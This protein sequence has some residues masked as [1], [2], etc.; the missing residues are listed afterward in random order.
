MARGAAAARRSG[1]GSV[2][3]WPA[4]TEEAAAAC[5]LRWASAA[6]YSCV[7]SAAATV[8]YV[9]PPD[10]TV[11][12]GSWSSSMINR[13]SGPKFGVELKI[14]GND[15]KTP[16]FLS[17]SHMQNHAPLRSVCSDRHGNW[18]GLAG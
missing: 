10:A 3:R 2:A 7:Y 17:G 4:P 1:I 9:L 13:S 16:S 15:Q 12:W 6:R 5:K 14:R 18:W 8:W 11:L